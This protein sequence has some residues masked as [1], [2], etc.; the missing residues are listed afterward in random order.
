MSAEQN[1]H[2]EKRDGIQFWT[3]CRKN[4]MASRKFD[5]LHK[6]KKIDDVGLAF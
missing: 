3:E 6:S 1:V 4:V 5:V 2:V